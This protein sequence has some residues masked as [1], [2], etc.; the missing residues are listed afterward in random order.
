MKRTAALMVMLLALV[1]AAFAQMGFGPGGG[2]MG[3]IGG[4]MGG[5]FGMTGSRGAMD[6]SIA[7]DGTVL[8]G[9]TLYNQTSL[10]FEILA[11]T[12]AGVKAWTYP[13]A[14]PL[15]RI[16]FVGSLA[17]VS[18]TGAALRPGTPRPDFSSE[19]VALNLSSGTVAWKLPLDGMAMA[20]QGTATQIYVVVMSM[21]GER[22]LLAVST[23]GQ[24][25]WT[26]TL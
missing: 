12:P 17:L 10:S 8:V 3:G 16:D 23:A 2:M 1:P 18:S 11:L 22:K 15:H 9:R 4:T 6:V 13:S 5:G 24:V 20:V 25:L 14:A 7:P 26:Q 19:L 21:T